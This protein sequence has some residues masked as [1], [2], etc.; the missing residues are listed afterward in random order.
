[1][2]KA[3]EHQGKGKKGGKGDGEIGQLRTDGTLE[4][5]SGNFSIVYTPYVFS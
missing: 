4:E 5:A 3:V 2:L 1:M